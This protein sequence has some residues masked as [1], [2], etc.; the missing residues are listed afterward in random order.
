MELNAD[1]P[2][3][4]NK[5]TGEAHTLMALRYRSGSDDG[6][7]ASYG[8]PFTRKDGK[9]TDEKALR[10]RSGSDDGT[11]ASYGSP[12]TRKDGKLT[13]EKVRQ[14]F[15]RFTNLFSRR[16]TFAAGTI[17]Q[18]STSWL[19]QILCSFDKFF[20]GLLYMKPWNIKTM[21]IAEAAITAV[22]NSRTVTLAAA[23]PPSGRYDDLNTAQDSID[24]QTTIL[25]RVDLIF[26]VKGIRMFKVYSSA[27]AANDPRDTKDDNCLK[28]YIQ[29]CRIMS[30]PLL[31]KNAAKSLQKSYVKIRQ[32]RLL[33]LAAV[34]L[35]L[36]CGCDS[37]TTDVAVASEHVET[38][39]RYDYEANS[40]LFSWLLSIGL[41]SQL[42]K[43][44]VSFRLAIHL[45]WTTKK[46]LS[47]T[48]SRH[49]YAHC[50]TSLP[51]EGT[52][53]GSANSEATYP[54]SRMLDSVRQKALIS[55][56]VF[57][58]K[59]RCEIKENGV[60]TDSV[61]FQPLP[62]SCS[63]YNTRKNISDSPCLKV[64]A[65]AK[66]YYYE[67]IIIQLTCLFFALG[68]AH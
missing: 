63:I 56:T 19:G 15:K 1:S 41:F 64:R 2:Y 13:D 12:F 6:T 25:S 22:L 43:R 52:N 46:K 68:L 57:F 39:H 58:T 20:K 24:L 40:I 65:Y 4:K 54:C 60:A 17:V 44:F 51:S 42:V 35:I 45:L 62:V 26:I 8:S 55:G 50:V 27:N 49:T 38:V 61:M 30:R 48:G 23:N 7:R 33:I 18:Q 34:K 31:S 53:H 21:S 11:R 3:E 14:P 16:C 5:R 36:L 67:C 66:W 47:D 10:Y 37:V 29:Y 59:E 9:L 28:R 32:I